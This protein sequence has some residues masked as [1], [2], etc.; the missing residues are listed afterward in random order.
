MCLFK[1]SKFKPKGFGYK[2]FLSNYSTLHGIY[3]ND[4]YNYEIG[5]SYTANSK[6]T[7][8]TY[9]SEHYKAGFHIFQSLK[10]AKQYAN[11]LGA[12]KIA[13]L[14][15][16]KVR[17]PLKSVSAVGLEHHYKKVKPKVVV[18]KRMTLEK[19]I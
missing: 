10:D 9:S 4:V 16:V 3:Y 15:I 1:L 8:K 19:I 17:Y 5:K 6:K 14:K 2:V 7:I 18:A 11:F 12:Y 13:K